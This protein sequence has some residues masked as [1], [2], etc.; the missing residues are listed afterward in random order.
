MH[1]YKIPTFTQKTDLNTHLFLT[2]V[3]WCP[4]IEYFK[5]KNCF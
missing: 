4:K 2:D 5:N 3:Y 1:E